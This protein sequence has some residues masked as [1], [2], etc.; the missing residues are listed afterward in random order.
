MEFVLNEHR[1]SAS[2]EDSAELVSYVARKGT[3]FIPVDF[4]RS[5]E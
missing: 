4:R 3:Y 2:T 5:Y 1:V